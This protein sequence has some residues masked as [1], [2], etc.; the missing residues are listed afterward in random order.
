MADIVPSNV[1]AAYRARKAMYARTPALPPVSGD[2]G[3]GDYY[4]IRPIGD[5]ARA[6]V[7]ATADAVI[8]R[9][10]SVTHG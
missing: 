7:L 8:E 5:W 10:R 2:D 9:W 1:V 4:C 6:C 3:D